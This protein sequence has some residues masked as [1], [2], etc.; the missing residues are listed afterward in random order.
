MRSETEGVKLVDHALAL[1]CQRN[2]Q[3]RR[4]RRC[5]RCFDDAAAVSFF[6]PNLLRLIQ[7]V[8]EEMINLRRSGGTIFQLTREE[9]RQA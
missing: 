1:R 5:R 2:S 7:G 3:T 6:F 4:R 8:E 9:R